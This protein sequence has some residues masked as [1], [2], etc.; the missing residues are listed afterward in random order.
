MVLRHLLEQRE[1]RKEREKTE[2]QLRADYELGIRIEKG[3]RDAYE[4]IIHE[5]YEKGRQDEREAQN[6]ARCKSSDRNGAEE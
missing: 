2:Q 1:A 3:I 4:K 6:T 5:A